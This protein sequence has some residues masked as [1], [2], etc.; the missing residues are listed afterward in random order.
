MFFPQSHWEGLRQNGVESAGP[1]P[2]VKSL[3]LCDLAKGSAH[4][5]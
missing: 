5:H 1:D 4:C 2:G 3:G